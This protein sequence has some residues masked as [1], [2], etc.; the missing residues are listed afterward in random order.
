MSDILGL[1]AMT[2]S[3]ITYPFCYKLFGQKG[4]TKLQILHNITFS[5]SVSVTSAI[6]LFQLLCIS[7]VASTSHPIFWLD[8]QGLNWISCHFTRG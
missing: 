6:P 3:D 8:Q 5:S 7:Q 4:K 1:V 2:K